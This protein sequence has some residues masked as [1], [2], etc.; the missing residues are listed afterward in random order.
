MKKYRGEILVSLVQTAYVY[1]G[2]FIG[3]TVLPF[4]ISGTV[5][6]NLLNHV[7]L[8]LAAFVI[9]WAGVSAVRI[10]QSRQRR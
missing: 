6:E 10:Y 9:L 5:P 2:I 3:S 8:L 7:L 4:L 1:I